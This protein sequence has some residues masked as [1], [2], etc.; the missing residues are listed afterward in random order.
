MQLPEGFDKVDEHYFDDTNY[1]EIIGTLCYNEALQPNDKLYV[2]NAQVALYKTLKM[3]VWQRK[4][5][6]FLGGLE[7]EDLPQYGNQLVE[8]VLSKRSPFIGLT[9]AEVCHDINDK[10]ASAII[11][12][13]S[14]NDCDATDEALQKVSGVLFTCIDVHRADCLQQCCA[15]P[16]SANLPSTCASKWATASSS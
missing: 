7:I 8:C 6:K 13:R 15:L 2:A 16:C 5:I 12:A 9:L 3:M 11:S 14:H 4:G 1:T 10:Y